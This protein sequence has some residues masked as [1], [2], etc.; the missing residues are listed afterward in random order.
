M[1]KMQLNSTINYY[2]NQADSLSKR[3]ESADISLLQKLLLETFSKNSNLMEI[4]C[5]SGRDAAFM[6]KNNYHVLG[7][8]AS[9]NMIYEAKKLHPELKEI[10]KVSIVPEDLDF[11]ESKF[12][13]IYSI[14]TLMHLKETD[15]DKTLAKIYRLLKNKGRL[16]FSVPVNRSGLNQD[17]N[18]DKG[19]LFT[20]LDQDKWI[21]ICLSKGFKILKIE[22][23]DDGLKRDNIKWLTC[24][25]EK[26]IGSDE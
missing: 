15:I 8:D 26:H 9:K 14:A 19:R 25:M 6:L 11:K 20:I 10:L 13:G 5:G 3:Y 22:I 24:I 17:H 2:N 16:L 7:L 12:D 21:D 18:D 1:G 23:S 4:G